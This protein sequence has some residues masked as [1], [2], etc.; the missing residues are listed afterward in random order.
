M[1]NDDVINYIKT[2]SEGKLLED[3]STTLNIPITVIPGHGDYAEERIEFELILS[4]IG[5]NKL[6]TIQKVGKI[7]GLNLRDARNIVN[8]IPISLG[9]FTKEETESIVDSFDKLG[10]KISYRDTSVGRRHD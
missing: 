8:N 1:T 7:T 10:A 3:L 9:A 2:L 4:S 5:D 6:Q